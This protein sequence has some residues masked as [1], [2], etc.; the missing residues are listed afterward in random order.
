MIVPSQKSFRLTI[1]PIAITLIAFGVSLVTVNCGNSFLRQKNNDS[2]EVS[3][4]TV[5]VE[6]AKLRKLR[7]YLTGPGTV[8]A[9]NTVT[10]KS[11]ID[12][13]IVRIEF[14]EGQD[15]K[16][17]DLLF[18]IDPAPYQA[19]LDRTEATLYRDQGALKD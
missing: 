1:R 19:A 12:G 3:K 17:G 18:V 6:A 2:T 9:Y 11:R 4:V 13:Q 7:T 14:K 5:T 10:L 8:T 16:K 15:V